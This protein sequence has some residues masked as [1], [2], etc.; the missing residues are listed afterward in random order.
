MYFEGKDKEFF[1]GALDSSLKES[2]ELKKTLR[3]G[4]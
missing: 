1:T 4:D 3:F 2:K